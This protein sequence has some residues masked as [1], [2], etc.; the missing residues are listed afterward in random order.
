MYKF[1]IDNLLKVEVVDKNKPLSLNVKT[2][3]AKMFLLLIDTH[4]LP[5]S[6]LHKIFN[7]NTVNVSYS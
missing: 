7:R 5:A 2:N 6:K 1:Q 3:I 4:F